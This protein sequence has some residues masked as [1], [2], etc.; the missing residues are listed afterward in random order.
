ME[1]EEIREC[2]KLIAEFMGYKY[3]PLPEDRSYNPGWWKGDPIKM[4]S[5]NKLNENHLLCRSYNDLRYYNSW[6]WLMSVVYK[7]F[8]EGWVT[9][10][11][12]NYCI[13]QDK[14]TF[15]KRED[16]DLPYFD[17]HSESPETLIKAVYECVVEFIK[18]QNK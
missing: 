10:F 18:Y 11:Y 7:I 13:I 17:S 1:R 9:I 12:S 6:D 15:T 14:A 2:N 4:T 3:Y 16:N 5:F 8:N